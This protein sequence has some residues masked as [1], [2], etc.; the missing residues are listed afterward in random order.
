MMFTHLLR[1]SSR[2]NSSFNIFVIRLL[3]YFTT[4]D[5]FEVYD[6]L[7]CRYC[8]RLVICAILG[9]SDNNVQLC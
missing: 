7:R 1:L 4:G 9:T 2:D 8:W 5:S 6:L 3:Q